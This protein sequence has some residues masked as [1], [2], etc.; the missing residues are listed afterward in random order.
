MNVKI[1]LLSL[2]VVLLMACKPKSEEPTVPGTPASKPNW[3]MVTNPDY[4]SSMTLICVPPTGESLSSNDE[5]AVFW[6]DTCRATATSMNN[7]FFMGISG[8]TTE[9]VMELRYYSGTYRTLRT[10]QMTYSPNAQIGSV[11]APYVLTFNQ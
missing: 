4:Q 2:A 6:N 8:P 1:P 9:Q 7:V 3:V 5:V 11:D 10:T